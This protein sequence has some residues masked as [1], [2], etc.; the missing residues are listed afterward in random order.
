MF[1]VPAKLRIARPSR[2]RRSRI[3]TIADASRLL[4]QYGISGLPVVDSANRLV[5]FTIEGDFLL[6]FHDIAAL[7][8]ISVQSGST[9]RGLSAFP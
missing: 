6:V 3:V 2:V 9:R 8:R 1:A 4:L 5:G 7:A